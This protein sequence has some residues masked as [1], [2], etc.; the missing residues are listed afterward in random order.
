MS[1]SPNML[2]TV[3]PWDMVA[4]GYAETSMKLF[5]SYTERALEVTTIS[6]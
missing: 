4:E 2:S 6:K 3:T 5:R 1:K